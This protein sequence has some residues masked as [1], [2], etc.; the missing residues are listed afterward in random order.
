MKVLT[1]YAFIGVYTLS[2]SEVIEIGMCIS[3]TEADAIHISMHCQQSET[4]KT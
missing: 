3:I 2:G 4:L 1:L